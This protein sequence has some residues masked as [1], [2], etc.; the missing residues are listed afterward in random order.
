M[1]GSFHIKKALLVALLTMLTA[2]PSF[3][4]GLDSMPLIGSKKPNVAEPS[5]EPPPLPDMPA[6]KAPV[7]PAAIPPLPISNIC[8]QSDMEGLWKLQQVYEEPAGSASAAFN[9][10]PIQYVYYKPNGVYGKYNG[11]GGLT[12]PALIIDHIDKHA[13]GLQQ[14]LLQNTGIVYYYQ[15]KI[16]NDTQTC[17]IV[18]KRKDPFMPGDMLLMPPK[19]QIT[20]RLIKQYSKV[21]SDQA[22]VAPAD[23]NANPNPYRPNRLNSRLPT[24]PTNP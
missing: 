9:L 10:N 2:S 20:G 5:E 12:T 3:A 13:A 23:N 19:G 8:K 4:I 16:A 22:P 17:F 21:I 1:T 6:S 24:N 15:D 14:Y 18:L 7:R 11:D